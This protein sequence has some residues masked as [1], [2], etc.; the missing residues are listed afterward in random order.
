[1]SEIRLWFWS[2]SDRQGL[3]ALLEDIQTSV[4][5]VVVSYIS[6]VFSFLT[7]RPDENGVVLRGYEGNSTEM[8][9]SGHGRSSD[10][11]QVEITP[12]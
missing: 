5:D 9:E 10:D 3:T 7:E 6:T 8:D 2:D 1:M 4:R 11:V 12:T